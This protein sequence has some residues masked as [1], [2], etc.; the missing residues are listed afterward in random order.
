MSARGINMSKLESSPVEG[1][2]FLFDFFLDID[3]SVKES[4]VMAMLEDLER[5][6][7]GLHFLGSYSVV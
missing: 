4:G 5:S 6:C 7:D 1:Q 2:D 3:A